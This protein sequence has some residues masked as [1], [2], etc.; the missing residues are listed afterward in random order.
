MVKRSWVR[1]LLAI[2]ILIACSGSAVAGDRVELGVQ[3]GFLLPGRD[4]TGRSESLDQLEPT[5]GLRTGVRLAP[6]WDWT[7]DLGWSGFEDVAENSIAIL[8]GRTGVAWYPSRRPDRSR[9]FLSLGAGAANLDPEGEG[10]DGRT[11]VSVG[12]GQRLSCCHRPSLRWELRGDRLWNGEDLTDVQLLLAAN[13]GRGP[14]TQR[15]TPL[16]PPEP[17]VE[18]PAEPRVESSV[19]EPAAHPP[20]PPPPLRPPPPPPSPTPPR[21]VL[22]GVNFEFDSDRLTADSIAILDRVAEVLLELGSPRTEIG[23]HTDDWGSDNYN[24]DLS[25]RRAEAVKRHLV[26]AGVAEDRLFPRGYG[27]T[28]PITTNL[29]EERRSINRRVELKRLD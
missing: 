11:L 10:S 7:L 29:T 2:G 1:S 14:K 24:F 3:G 15:P 23:G 9:W 17:P 16:P 4:L 18:E 13:W 28:E 25:R 20:S 6:R 22:E 5:I 26:A 19:P 8:R 21:V 12:V 27:E